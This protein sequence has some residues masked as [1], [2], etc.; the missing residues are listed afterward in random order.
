MRAKLSASL[1]TTFLPA[2]GKARDYVWDT[3]LPG[4]GLMVTST[5]ARS[6]CVQYRVSGTGRSRRMRIGTP[7]K[8]NLEKARQVALAKLGGVAQGDDPLKVKIDEREAHRVGRHDTVALLVERYL[9]KHAKLH[10]RTHDEL[11]RTLERDVCSKWGRK[12][13]S[14]IADTDVA[15]LI[16]AIADRAPIQANRTLTYLRMFLGWCVDRRI[17][18]VSP[19]VGVKPPGTEQTRDRVLSDD[20]LRAVW[21][22]ADAEGHP[23]GACAKLLILTA[24]RR[25]E[26]AGISW[27]ELDL[28]AGTWI[29]PGDR[30]KN[31]ETHE[32]QLSS[33]AV[34][35]LEAAP[36]VDDVELVFS[37][38]GKTA[39]SGFSKFKLRLDEASGVH[40]WRFHDLRRTATTGMARLGVP[41]HVVDK[42]LNHSQGTIRGVAAVYNRFEYQ[43]ERRNALQAWAHYVDHVVNDD[44]AALANVVPMR[45]TATA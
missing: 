1:V 13:I 29:I 6:Y 2:E 15:K 28:K 27:P 43:P 9:T 18:K 31:G 36:R 34:A 24:Q 5:G 39:V 20:E 38:T 12:A 4:F 22:A 11:K 26:V 17:L 44:P 3:S 37:S 14:D 7:G 23:F 25:N 30:A 41:P 8:M 32:V 33:Q 10:L 45:S 35:I 16:D 42:I 19:A 40:G 21:K